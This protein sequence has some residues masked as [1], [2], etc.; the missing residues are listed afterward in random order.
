M[1]ATFYCYCFRP[2]SGE[3]RRVDYAP[4][5]TLCIF[6]GSSRMEVSARQKCAAL[7]PCSNFCCVGWNPMLLYINCR[8]CSAFVLWIQIL[9][10]ECDS[11]TGEC[12]SVRWFCYGWVDSFFNNFSRRERILVRLCRQ[13]SFANKRN[14]RVKMWRCKWLKHIYAKIRFLFLII[15]AYKNIQSVISSKQPL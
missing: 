8:M 2:P 14:I 11:P 13:V 5:I 3:I 7:G 15:L 1:T 6:A 9:C 12:L 4:T 10:L